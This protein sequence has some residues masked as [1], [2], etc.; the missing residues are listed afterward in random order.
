MGRGP[1][2]GKV[3][4][5]MGERVPNPNVL[6]AGRVNSGAPKTARLLERDSITR[7][8]SK[9]MGEIVYLWVGIKPYIGEQRKGRRGL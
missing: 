5:G 6:R 7:A 8:K 4:P 9:G 2:L 1:T 3:Y